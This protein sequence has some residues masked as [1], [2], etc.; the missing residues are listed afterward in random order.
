MPRQAR[1]GRPS[2]SRYFVVR[3]DVGRHN[4]V[5]KILGRAFMDKVDFRRSCILTSGRIAADMILKAVAAGVP[6]VV[7]RSI[8]TTAALE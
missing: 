6:V 5:D 7:S 2:G 1:S 4:A 8:P 3:E